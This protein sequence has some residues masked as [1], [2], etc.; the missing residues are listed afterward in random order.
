MTTVLSCLCPCS[1]TC[2]MSTNQAS[3]QNA[4]LKTTVSQCGTEQFRGFSRS[5]L[6]CNRLHQG[7]VARCFKDSVERLDAKSTDDVRELKVGG[8][9]E[10]TVRQVRL[11]DLRIGGYYKGKITVVE[12]YGVFVDIGAPVDGFVHISRLD[13]LLRRKEEDLMQVGQDVTVQIVD[14]NPCDESISILLAPEEDSLM[15]VKLQPLALSERQ[16]LNR[17]ASRRANKTAARGAEALSMRRAMS[18][19]TR[20]RLKVHRRV[21]LAEWQATQLHQ[22]RSRTSFCETPEGVLAATDDPG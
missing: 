12:S 15:T 8:T 4:K 2:F 17:T 1:L 19:E 13:K 11:E 10:E 3:P 6:V 16:I 18:F 9:R 20:Q 14:L 7:L 21:V 22:V 5:L